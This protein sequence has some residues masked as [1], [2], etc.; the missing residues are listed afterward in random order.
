MPK[1]SIPLAQSILDY[2]H[3]GT[4]DTKTSYIKN[5]Y[6]TKNSLNNLLVHKREGYTNKYTTLSAALKYPLYTPTNE[7]T[8]KLFAIDTSGY[9]IEDGTRKSVLSN[10]GLSTDDFS[11]GWCT[12]DY[13]NTKYIYIHGHST[14]GS[15]SD[16]LY[17][18][19]ADTLT[20]ITD[21]DHP[22]KLGSQGW[23]QG[24][25]F[26]DGYVFVPGNN[27]RVY[28][29][30]INNPTSWVATD[31]IAV[32]RE[33]D[34]IVSIAKIKDHIVVFGTSSIEFFYNAGNPT[35]SPLARRP[36]IFYSIGQSPYTGIPV[37][38]EEA[39]YFIGTDSQHYRTNDKVYK[40]TSNLELQLISNSFIDSQINSNNVNTP[41]RISGVLSIN[42]KNFLC[43]ALSSSET[44]VYDLELKV[45]YPWTINTRSGV[46]TN[47]FIGNGE[48]QLKEI[49]HK[50][51]VYTDASSNYTFEIVTP[52][53]NKF[54]SENEN[55]A[56]KKFCS[57]LQITG[58]RPSIDTNISVS[59]SDDDYAT[60]STARDY[61]MRYADSKLT[62]LGSFR[63]RAF[64][65]A[66][67]GTQGLNLES[68]VLDIQEGNI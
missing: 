65:L 61:N 5:G 28:N 38:W 36:D 20:E 2:K 14:S 62:R 46:T 10:L 44:L 45:W 48:T 58:N 29:S 1:I 41:V 19:S 66:Y 67:T 37:V 59:Y 26:L 15:V 21:A 23:N 47:I 11:I 9:M 52:K 35:G 6:I 51:P 42:G 40:L 33:D 54:N 4:F 7:D 57:S 34:S 16:Y 30:V 3:L 55:T 22:V 17:N 27:N 68:L 25:V 39:L 56:L 49:V 43:V 31:Y 32:T 13:S 64:K 60:F 63:E 53:L 24:A 12:V 18:Y 8:S 50:V